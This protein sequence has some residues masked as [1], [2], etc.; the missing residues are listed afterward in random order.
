MCV[1][2][3]YVYRKSSHSSEFVHSLL[4][5]SLCVLKNVTIGITQVI[6][7]WGKMKQNGQFRASLGYMMS[8]FFFSQKKGRQS[9]EGKRRELEEKMERGKERRDRITLIHQTLRVGAQGVYACWINEHHTKRPGSNRY[10][11]ISKNN[12][13]LVMSHRFVKVL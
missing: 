12:A 8:F 6:P 3:V 1:P 10:A 5:S 13:G 7:A 2:C 11:H 9:G 4:L